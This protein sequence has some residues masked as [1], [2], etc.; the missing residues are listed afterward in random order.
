MRFRGILLT[1]V[2]LLVLAMA[3]FNWGV[4]TKPAPLDLL[5]V[6][7]EV[8][9]G[10]TLLL[11]LLVLASLFFLGALVDRASQL[12]QVTHLERQSDALRTRVDD[13]RA[14]ELVHL[15]E[16]VSAD[17]ESLAS[18]F[19]DA[20]AKATAPAAPV[21]AAPTEAEA[22]A[23]AAN[24]QALDAFE[25]RLLARLEDVERRVGLVRNE[26]AADIAQSED[27]LLRRFDGAATAQDGDVETRDEG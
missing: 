27:A 6:T 10:L 1:I 21:P 7:V 19:D 20:M 25:A 17:L 2:V 26:L 11:A 4:L 24:L 15:E 23:D 18:R 9:L 16:R 8:P 22:D 13:N 3:V 14:A 12:R 5:F